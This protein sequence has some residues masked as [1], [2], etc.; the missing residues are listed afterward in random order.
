M[1][2]TKWKKMNYKFI[3]AMANQIRINNMSEGKTKRW[4]T[5]AKREHVDKL[6]NMN[7]PQ[8][9]KERYKPPLVKHFNEIGIDKNNLGRVKY[10]F[11][12]KST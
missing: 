8:E 11:F 9:Y 4:T 1:N 3:N 5:E 6:A 7:V 2:R 12:T 10:F